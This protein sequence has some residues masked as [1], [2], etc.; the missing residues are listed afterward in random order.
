M[1][2]TPSGAAVTSFRIAVGRTYTTSSGER[3]E[4]TEWFTVNA[5][6]QLAEVVNQYLTKGRQVYVEG[7]LSSRTWTG[8]DGQQRFSNEIRANEIVFLGS[9]GP[10]E[11]GGDDMAAPPGPTDDDLPW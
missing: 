10:S 11:G 6:N 2:Y 3:R 9:G 8:Q 1:R 4:E 5:W 7:R